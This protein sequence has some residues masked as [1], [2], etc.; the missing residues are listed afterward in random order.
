MDLV[1]VVMGAKSPHGPGSSFAIASK[2]RSSAF[3]NY[4]L[5]TV[6]KKGAT[7]GQAPVA[8][9]QSRTVPAV[10]GSDVRAL[11]KRGE[12][13]SVKVSL[14]ANNVTAP[15]HAGQQVGNVVVSQNGQQVSR[16]PAVAGANVDKQSWWKKFWP[17]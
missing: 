4:N 12:E 13:S 17:F 7:V 9:G 3:A 11:V 1:A 8:D 15:V 6:V 10:A 16:V 2:L 14:A 5:V